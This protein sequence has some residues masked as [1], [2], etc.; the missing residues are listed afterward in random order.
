M[1][2]PKNQTYCQYLYQPAFNFTTPSEIHYININSLQIIQTF[3][4]WCGLQCQL[5]WLSGSNHSCMHCGE[6]QRAEPIIAGNWIG[7][8]VDVVCAIN[9][10]NTYT[11]WWWARNTLICC[12]KYIVVLYHC[13]FPR[14][15]WSYH[16][17]ISRYEDVT[18]SSDFLSTSS[19]VSH[20]FNKYI[21]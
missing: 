10:E 7:C 18:K 17:C 5:G 21:V 3:Y 9:V 19:F 14:W 6:R 2:V 8:R 20:I 11:K 13:R 1:Y 16:L 4:Q 12:I 15:N